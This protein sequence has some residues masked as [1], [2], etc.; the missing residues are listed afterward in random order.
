MKNKYSPSNKDRK[1]YI[2]K[3]C[4]DKIRYVNAD[5]AQNAVDDFYQKVVIS[6]H[7]FESYRCHIHGC[8]HVGHRRPVNEIKKFH[9][10]LREIRYY[11]VA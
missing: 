10:M 1:E 8:F 9:R 4:N 7:P 5:D 11:D 3:D 6:I 2:I